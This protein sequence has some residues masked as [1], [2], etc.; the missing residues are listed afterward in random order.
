MERLMSF[1]DND[2]RFPYYIATFMSNLGVSLVRN[3]KTEIEEWKHLL[4]YRMIYNKNI[5]D[6]EDM[7]YAKFLFDNIENSVK[8]TAE[9]LTLVSGQSDYEDE[10]I[11]YDRFLNI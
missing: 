10:K 5:W 11:E 9:W 2:N 6:I 8:E 1:F 3:K 4:K 7:S